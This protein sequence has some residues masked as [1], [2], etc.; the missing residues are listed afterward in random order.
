MRLVAPRWRQAMPFPNE[1]RPEDLLTMKQ[2]CAKLS[3]SRSLLRAQLEKRRMLVVRVGRKIFVPSQTCTKSDLGQVPFPRRS[4]EKV[5]E[6]AWPRGC[7]SLRTALECHYTPAS[8]D[9]VAQ[10]DGRR[11]CGPGGGTYL[12]TTRHQGCPLTPIYTFHRP[13]PRRPTTMDTH[14]RRCC[15][16]SLNT[17]IRTNVH[18]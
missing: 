2:A 16:M 1:I 7:R 8:R 11:F 18:S 6:Q 12:S 3:I 9:L 17:V 10:F 5:D 4:R 13:S 14:S 15:H